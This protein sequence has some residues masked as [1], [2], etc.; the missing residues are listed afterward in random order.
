MSTGHQTAVKKWDFFEATIADLPLRIQDNVVTTSLVAGSLQFSAGG[1][2]ESTVDLGG[3]NGFAKADLIAFEA[4]LKTDLIDDD[5]DIRV[6]MASAY[7]ADPDVIAESA[8]FK[9]RGK[10]GAANAND[11]F[12]ET[13]DGTTDNNDIACSKTMQVGAWHR[14]RIDFA[15]GIQSISPPGTS[16]GGFGA[17]LFSSA[18][19]SQ[20]NNFMDV[21]KP[22]QHMDMSA[23]SGPLAPFVQVRLVGAPDATVTVD[24]REI[25]VEYKVY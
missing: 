25:C 10:A 7:N 3:T 6:G 14:F 20:G 23:A 5:L 11:V 16:K 24:L 22:A 9:I 13:D 4:V 2:G 8:W 12:L 15:K 19:E 1:T 21:C 18:R 17:V